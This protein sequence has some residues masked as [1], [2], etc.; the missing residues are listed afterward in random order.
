MP[1][2][3]S[4]NESETSSEDLVCLKQALQTNLRKAGLVGSISLQF[5]TIIARKLIDGIAHPL[6]RDASDQM[7]SDASARVSASCSEHEEAI[8]TL[9]F[10][11]MRNVGLKCT[12]S[13]FVPEARIRREMMSVKECIL[14]LGIQYKTA[15]YDNAIS[16][17]NHQS[18]ADAAESKPIVNS[19]LVWFIQIAVDRFLSMDGSSSVSSQTEILD[20]AESARSS[21]NFEL[22][23]LKEKYDKDLN[24]ESGKQ[25]NYVEECIRTFQ[26]KCEARL[27]KDSREKVRQFLECEAS[28]IHHEEETKFKLELRAV[29]AELKSEYDSRLQ[30]ALS[31]L[32]KSR[33]EMCKMQQGEVIDL[34]IAMQNLE[35]R[36]QKI[37]SDEQRLD[38][39]L[40]QADIKLKDAETKSKYASEEFERSR[41]QAQKSYDGALATLNSQRKLLDEDIANLSA[42][43]ALFEDAKSEIRELRQNLA[44]L[45]GDLDRTRIKWNQT[46]SELEAYKRAY[47]NDE[48][49]AVKEIRLVKENISLQISLDELRQVMLQRD[50]DYEDLQG[51]KEETLEKLRKCENVRSALEIDLINNDNKTAAVKMEAERYKTDLNSALTEAD[52]LRILLNKSQLA[53]EA[54]RSSEVRRRENIPRLKNWVTLNHTEDERSMRPLNLSNHRHSLVMPQKIRKESPRHVFKS[55]EKVHSDHIQLYQPD[56]V[57]RAMDKRQV[58]LT[59][60]EFICGVDYVDMRA[61][62]NMSQLT[63][64]KSLSKSHLLLSLADATEAV[65]SS[66]MIN[67]L[68]TDG[69]GEKTGPVPPQP[70]KFVPSSVRGVFSCCIIAAYISFH[71][72]SV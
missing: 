17:W 21:L 2:E 15:A 29:K 64:D 33:Q 72:I 53:L 37:K 23:R 59:A 38:M 40:A 56:C 16:S 24:V 1:R 11:Y 54:M 49:L 70:D 13:I 47:E 3:Y 30:V 7:P 62:D 22:D 25:E 63:N 39:T 41:M 34:T 27:E 55:I 48:C 12:L 4:F 18:S 44:A 28:K 52:N 20:T 61:L 50:A 35:C 58:D 6:L 14:A 36:E 31:N 26:E 66:S 8:R 51:K 67:D 57:N 71:S 65:N 5:R 10:Y 42:E 45:Q 60:K 69:S 68:C 43:R 32:E 9:I 46:N 19:M